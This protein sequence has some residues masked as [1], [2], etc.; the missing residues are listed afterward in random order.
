MLL[1]LLLAAAMVYV[2]EGDCDELEI[3]ATMMRHDEV[4]T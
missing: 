4:G 2:A 1:V 3:K